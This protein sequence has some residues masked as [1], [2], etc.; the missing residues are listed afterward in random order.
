MSHPQNG[1]ASAA[2]FKR[3]VR[4][5]DFTLPVGGQKV[6]IADMSAADMLDWSKHTGTNMTQQATLKAAHILTTYCVVDGA[7]EPIWKR[8]DLSYLDDL[9]TNDANALAEAVQ[10]HCGLKDDEEDETVKN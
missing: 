2:D 1:Y 3:Q 10:N 5:H 7:G 6:R 8:G 4:F 9:D